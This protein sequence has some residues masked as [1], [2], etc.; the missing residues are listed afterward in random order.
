LASWSPHDFCQHTGM[1]CVHETPGPTARP[2]WLW[3]IAWPMAQ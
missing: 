3:Q 2:Q 1:P